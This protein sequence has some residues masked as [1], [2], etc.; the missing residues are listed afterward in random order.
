MKVG[1]CMSVFLTIAP[2]MLPRLQRASGRIGEF[3]KRVRMRLYQRKWYRDKNNSKGNPCR[4]SRRGKT[5]ESMALRAI[6]LKWWNIRNHDK[7]KALAK[8]RYSNACPEER[9]A[10]QRVRRNANPEVHRAKWRE[11]AKKNPAYF[12][13]EKRRIPHLL[14]C[15]IRARVKGRNVKKDWKYAPSVTVRFLLWLAEK[16]GVPKDRHG[17]QIDHIVPADALDWNN[18]LHR[19][20]FNSPTNVRWLTAFDNNSKHSKIPHI[21]ELGRH[22]L[23]V[24]EFYRTL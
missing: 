11:W 20:M 17:Y 24:E 5:P 2:P 8:A 10:K 16:T 6:Y 13:S 9:N 4:F 3:I 12:L 23:L 21:S 15:A 18:A 19:K 14:R 22:F 1:H 7:I